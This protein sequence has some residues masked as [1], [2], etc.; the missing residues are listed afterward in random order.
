MRAL[1]SFLR[2]WPFLSLGL[3]TFGLFLAVE[4]LGAQLRP[5]IPPLRVLIVPLWLMRNLEMVVGIG[6]W[7]GPLQVLVALPLLFLPYVAADLL[8]GWAR[9]RW[10]AHR[11]TAT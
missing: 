8:L 1:G 7:P 9:R 3:L 6:Y 10:G 11:A 5:L 4:A 2:N